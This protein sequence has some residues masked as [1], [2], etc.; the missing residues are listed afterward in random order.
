MIKLSV[1][2][3]AQY[4]AANETGKMDL[5]PTCRCSRSHRHSWRFEFIEVPQ[6]PPWTA[7]ALDTSWA[8]G[9]MSSARVTS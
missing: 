2:V 1:R 8:N 3:M 4:L 9:V 7:S 6:R 5:A